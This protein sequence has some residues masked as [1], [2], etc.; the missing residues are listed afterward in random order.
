MNDTLRESEIRA[1]SAADDRA[2]VEQLNDLANEQLSADAKLAYQYAHQAAKLAERCGYMPGHAQALYNQG[3]CCHLLARYGEALDKFRL[4]VQLHEQLG[5]EASIADTLRA[6]G[7]VYDDLGDYTQSLDLHLR[8]LRIDE[9]T[10][11]DRSRAN[12]LRTIGIIYSKSSGEEQGLPYYQQSLELSRQQGDIISSAK[13]LNNIGIN[14]KNLGRYEE[15]LA[16]LEEAMRL[17]EQSGN[18]VIPGGVLNNMGQTLERLGR[19]AEAEAVLREAVAKGQQSGYVMVEVSASIGLGEL[20]LH[21]G[22]LTEAGEFLHAALR[23]AQGMTS[24]PK[25]SECHRSL[26]E[27]YKRLDDHRTALE[28]FEAFQALER[29][30]FNEESDRKLKGLQISFQVSQTRREAEIHRLKHVELARAYEELRD[31]NQSLREAD[32]QKTQL[33]AQ[34]EKQNKEDGLTGLFNRRYLDQRLAEEF[35]R[36]Q[37]HHHPLSVALADLDFF[38]QIND[39]LSHAVGDEVLRSVARIFRANVRETDVVARYGGEEFAL[40][41]LEMDIVGAARACDKIRQ[42]VQDYDW[43][44]IHPDLAVTISIGVSDDASVESHDRMLGL[45]DTRLYQAKF[46]GKNQVRC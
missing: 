17:F 4:A 11:N 31:L 41:F 12:T 10:G 28:H 40:V 44:R 26:A 3:L 37:R 36:A 14:L 35:R 20:L 1:Q 16:A 25:I 46:N 23:I 19:Y 15:S 18:S 7:F 22:R 39:R 30:L 21:R 24:K 33:L 2:K 13:T 29:Q 38:K 5:N 32:K 6:K 43:Q 9:A 42:A 27:L 8:A 45:A 34:L